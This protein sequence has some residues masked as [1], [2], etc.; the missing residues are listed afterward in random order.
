MET[1]YEEIVY[2]CSLIAQ[3]TNGELRSNL[4]STK[5]KLH[6]CTPISRKKEGVH[7]IWASCGPFKEKYDGGSLCHNEIKCYW[8]SK[9]DGKRIE[10]EWENLS[11]NDWLGNRFGG[12]SETARDKILRD[13]WRKRFGNEYDDSKDFEDPDGC[14]KSKENEILGTIINTL[15]DEW[16]KGMDVDDDNLEGYI[17]YLEPTLYDGFIDSDDEEYKE[18]KCRLLGMPCVKPPPILIEKSKVNEITSTILHASCAWYGYIKNH[19]K[20]VKNGQA[21]TQERKS[22]QK[23]KANPS[24]IF[25][26]VTEGNFL[27]DLY[28]N[29]FSGRKG[30]DAVEHI[31]YYLKII[32]PIKLPDVDHNKLRI[33]GFLI[34]LTGGARRW[35]DKTEESI[36][37]WNTDKEE[38]AK[39]FK[40]ET[41]VFNYETPLCLAFNKF[42]YLLKVDMDLLTKDIMGFKTYEDY[43]NDSYHIGN[44]LHYQDLEWYKALK[45]SELKD[46]ALR[47]KAIMEGLISDDESSNDCWKR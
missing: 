46:E 21:R 7:E 31:E 29:A 26:L 14:G 9:N 24:D 18:R 37:C 2:K 28:N 22:E 36:T 45:D 33:V 19:K 27:D 3:E 23:P 35:L 13:H 39:N 25:T 8:E 11:L 34:S 32:D 12:V 4:T 42:N 5:K 43:K 40:I 16:F 38:T 17:H 47:N 10:V 41:D 20:T 44:S 6:W 15:H 30:K 1:R